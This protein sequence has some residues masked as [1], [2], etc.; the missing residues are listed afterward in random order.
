MWAPMGIALLFGFLEQ[1]TSGAVG[2]AVVFGIL[3]LAVVGYGVRSLTQ[4]R[5]AS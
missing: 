2:F 4:Q 5:Q 1:A 3:F